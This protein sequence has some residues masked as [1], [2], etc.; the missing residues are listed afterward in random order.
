MANNTGMHLHFQY[1]YS[2]LGIEIDLRRMNGRD[3][4]VHIG[5]WLSK[6]NTKLRSISKGEKGGRSFQD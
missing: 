4:Q 6:F 1:V 3:R 5:E 2:E